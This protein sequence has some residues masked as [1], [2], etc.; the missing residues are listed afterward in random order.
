MENNNSLNLTPEP[1]EEASEES[2]LNPIDTAFLT[3]T[4]EAATLDTG[5]GEPLKL[6]P[7]DS[8]RYFAATSIGVKLFKL[9]PDEI[10]EFQL[11]GSYS[12]MLT[13]AIRL[14]FLCVQPRSI[15]NK[16]CR[17]PSVV[18]NESRAWAASLGVMPGS[19][20]H[21][22]IIEAFQGIVEEVFASSS[23]VDETG[24]GEDTGEGESLGKSSEVS[25]S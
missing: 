19:K 15:S 8:F 20:S 13:D 12:G 5:E 25:P 11:T 9:G 21:D 6:N 14:V 22:A 1:V 7:F 2:G 16:A 4:N 10:E 3:S 24:L 23:E 17:V 18:D